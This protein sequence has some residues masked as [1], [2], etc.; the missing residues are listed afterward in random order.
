MLASPVVAHVMRVVDG[1][2][3][4]VRAQVW[5][6]QSVEVLVRVRGIDAPERKG[7]CDHERRMAARASAYMRAMTASGRVVLTDISGGKYFGRV[8]ADVATSE[9][10]DVADA[11][12][13]RRLARP[14]KG[15]KRQSWCRRADNPGAA[16]D[17][18]EVVPVRAGRLFRQ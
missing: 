1:D 2:T 10:N 14:Y 16:I 18:R 17:P 9:G 4:A 7:R 8:L 13:G 15:R 6:G 5:I 11:L 3:I 12:L